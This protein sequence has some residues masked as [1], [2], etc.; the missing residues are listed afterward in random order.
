[1][2]CEEFIQGLKV[3]LTD[4]EMICDAIHRGRGQILPAARRLYLGLELKCEPILYEPQ[5]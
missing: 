3:N 5:I 1:M 4:L 2:L